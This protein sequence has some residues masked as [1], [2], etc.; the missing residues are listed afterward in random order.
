MGNEIYLLSAYAVAWA[1]IAC[2]VYI[3]IRKLGVIEQKIG[4]I[5]ERLGDQ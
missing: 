5:E 4:D 3:N 1:G 2:Y